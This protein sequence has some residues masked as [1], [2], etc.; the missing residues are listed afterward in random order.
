MTD[1]KTTPGSSRKIKRKHVFLNYT[2]AE[3]DAQY[4]QG[5]LGTNRLAYRE[6]WRA[7]TAR[8][9]RLLETRLD[10]PYGRA[11]V[12]KLDIYL[13]VRKT[14]KP[15]PVMVF[16][17]GGAW[18]AL[19]KDESAAYAPTYAAA[20]A[21]VV[22]PD[23]GAAPGTR[24]SEMVAQARRAIAWTWNNIADYGGGPDRIVVAGHSSGGHMAGMTLVGDWRGKAKL[25]EDAI[26]GGILFSGAYDLTPV[27]LSARNDYLKLSPAAAR[28]LSVTQAIPRRGCPLI[29]GVAE[30]DLHDFRR[31]GRAL[32]SAWKKA[33]NTVDLLDIAGV[34]HFDMGDVFADAKSPLGRATVHMLRKTGR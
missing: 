27:R 26:K 14:R 7:E 4:D 8:A 28:R 25:P 29:V 32:A 15:A 20:G 16:F 30:G 3:L 18:R 22:V 21:I 5:I 24:L 31:Q 11:E 9:Q 34:N 6:H 10:V 33:G 12:E 1:K 2:Q 13:P 19:T 23:F 17:H